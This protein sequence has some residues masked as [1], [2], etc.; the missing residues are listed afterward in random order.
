MVVNAWGQTEMAE[1]RTTFPLYSGGCVF[2]ASR[3]Q[4]ETA[5][6]WAA[7]PST[8]ND[9][10][11]LYPRSQTEMAEVWTSSPSTAVVVPLMPREARRKRLKSGLLPHPPR[12]NEAETGRTSLSGNGDALSIHLVHSAPLSL[13][14]S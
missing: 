12:T 1:V 4:A 9:A 13:Q 10:S 5:E 6:A 11:A 2:D 3:R 14:T 7:T 8:A